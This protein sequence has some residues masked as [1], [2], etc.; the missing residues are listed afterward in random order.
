MHDMNPMSKGD[1]G[2]M[3]PGA[4]VGFNNGMN[5]GVGGGNN[6]VKKDDKLS[7]MKDILKNFIK[8]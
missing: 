2:A 1:M 6:N 5:N 8:K 7:M 3:N 4:P